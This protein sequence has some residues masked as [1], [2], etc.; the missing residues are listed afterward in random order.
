MI[1]KEFYFITHG[2]P[3]ALSADGMVMAVTAGSTTM[4]LISDLWGGGG[5]GILKTLMST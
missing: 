3:N 1:Q 2:W 4:R 5:G